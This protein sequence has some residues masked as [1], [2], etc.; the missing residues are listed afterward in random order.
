MNSVF[1]QAVVAN[2]CKDKLNLKRLRIGMCVQPQIY[3][4]KQGI[5]RLAI[6]AFFYLA[7]LIGG[8]TEKAIFYIQ[9]RR[10]SS[11]QIVDAHLMS[12]TASV[13]FKNNYDPIACLLILK[14]CLLIVSDFFVYNEKIWCKISQCF[15]RF[16]GSVDSF[17]HFFHQSNLQ[18]NL[19]YV[20]DLK[21][22]RHKNRRK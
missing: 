12:R 3:Y 1:G 18:K 19:K 20:P 10:S 11:S 4:K 9:S 7:S 15:E 13:D 21:I 8:T 6:H 14:S 16:C 5:F 2:T 22:L 17:S